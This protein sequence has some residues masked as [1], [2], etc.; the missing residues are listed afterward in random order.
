MDDQR[1]DREGGGIKFRKLRIAWLVFWGVAAV[2]LFALWVR[3]YWRV[4]K[5]WWPTAANN[6]W[7]V[8]TFRGRTLVTVGGNYRGPNELQWALSRGGDEALT[9]R[10][11]PIY[12]FS[13]GP[14]YYSMPIWFPALLAVTLAAIPSAIK[15]VPWSNRFSLRTLI[16]ATTLV[17]VVLGIAVYAARK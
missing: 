7:A 1:T 9:D 15:A 8:G 11:K 4:D 16:I 14:R 17:A 5:I 13:F 10:S 12:G 6:S 3:S 2:L